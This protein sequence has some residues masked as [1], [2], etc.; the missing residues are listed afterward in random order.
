ML[1]FVA[2]LAVVSLSSAMGTSAADDPSTNTE[3]Y[4]ADFDRLCLSTGGRRDETLAVADASGW[5][6]APQALVDRFTSSSSP[7]VHLRFSSSLREDDPQRALL[8]VLPSRPELSSS[9]R[10]FDTCVVERAVPDQIDGSRLKELVDEKLSVFSASTSGPVTTWAFSGA[11]PFEDEA[12]V[13]AQ[14][15]DAVFDKGRAGPIFLLR[16]S[17]E[18][19]HSFLSLS[20]IGE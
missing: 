20:R 11:G 18:R 9:E 13:L 12:A 1:Q 5:A 8:T 14:G 10:T 19:G 3:H 17:V 7:E 6:P 15:M 16:L 2:A 4:F